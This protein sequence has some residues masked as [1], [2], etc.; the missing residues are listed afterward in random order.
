MT[1]APAIGQKVHHKCGDP[2]CDLVG[3]V[4]DVQNFAS[5]TLG[6]HQWYYQWAL[7]D[8]EVQR[9]GVVSVHR[10]WVPPERLD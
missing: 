2:R 9:E 7:V 8:W 5:R 10:M 1:G 6:D 4:V 3:T